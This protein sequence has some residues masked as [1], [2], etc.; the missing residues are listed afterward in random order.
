MRDIGLY[1]HRDA[2]A[3]SAAEFKRAKHRND[4]ARAGAAGTACNRA[5]CNGSRSDTHNYL[6]Q[7]AFSNSG[8]DQYAAGDCYTTPNQYSS[9][10]DQHANT[11]E[12]ANSTTGAD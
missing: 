7:T 5:A 6:N 9:T 12:A 10:A 3:D 1:R 2:G 4:L 8:C 11:N